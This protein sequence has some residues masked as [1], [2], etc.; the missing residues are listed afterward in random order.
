MLSII[1]GKHVAMEA[2]SADEDPAVG[3]PSYK[4]PQ[5][6]FDELISRSSLGGG[7]G[8]IWLHGK[9]GCVRRC[10]KKNCH[11]GKPNLSNEL[12]VK[13]ECVEHCL[14]KCGLLPNKQNVDFHC[15]LNWLRRLH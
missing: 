8:F 12:I 15:V 3:S 9:L 11:G 6:S 13:G 5:L 10:M 7:R 4:I 2:E 14:L 1:R